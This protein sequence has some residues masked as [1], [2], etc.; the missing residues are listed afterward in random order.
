MTA[1]YYS[2]RPRKGIQEVTVKETLAASIGPDARVEVRTD[3]GP[4]DILTRQYV[5]EIKRLSLAKAGLEQVLRYSRHYSLHTPKL[6]TFEDPKRE[7]TLQKNLA[8]VGARCAAAGVKF[9]HLDA[10]NMSTLLA[11]YPLRNCKVINTRNYLIFGGVPFKAPSGVRYYI[12][13]YLW[14]PGVAHDIPERGQ[15]VLLDLVNLSPLSIGEPQYCKVDQV[16][17]GFRFHDAK[18]SARVITLKPHIAACGGA[19]YFRREDSSTRLP[20]KGDII[21]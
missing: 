19:P 10:E 3:D 9:L 18:G 7:S 16:P 4:I 21:W 8:D 14:R 5:I 2:T 15:G 6:I 17:E 20:Q 1:T 11:R 12:K 13:T